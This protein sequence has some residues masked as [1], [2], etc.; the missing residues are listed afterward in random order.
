MNCVRKL[1]LFGPLSRL[2]TARQVSHLDFVLCINRYPQRIRTFVRGLVF[3]SHVF[4]NRIGFAN[5][6][7]GLRF[8]H[9]PQ[10][11]AQAIQNVADG[12]LTRQLLTFP[13]LLVVFLPSCGS[14]V[15]TCCR[16]KQS[17][18]G[19]RSSLIPPSSATNRISSPLGERFPRN[20]PMPPSLETLYAWRPLPLRPHP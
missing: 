18:C 9:A 5:L 17:P 20:N 19:V 13:A 1:E 10:T 4:E 11:I 3:S 16:R 15:R 12:F 6:L 8:L 7:H 14:R 2:T